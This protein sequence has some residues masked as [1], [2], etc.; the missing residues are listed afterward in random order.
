MALSRSLALLF[1]CAVSVSSARADDVYTFIIKKQEEKASTHWTLSEWLKTRDR[2]AL[3]DMWLALHSPSPYE[4]YLGGDLQAASRTIGSNY[5]AMRAQAGA[6]ASIFGLGIE[7]E[8]AP[9]NQSIGQ[10]NLRIFGYHDQ[11]TNITLHGGVRTRT[12]PSAF[13]SAIT[14]VS[15]TIYISRFFGVDGEWRH[16]F[17]A[18]PSESSTSFVGNRF[19]GGAFI[20]FKFLRLY[21][22]YFQE[23]DIE[24]SGVLGG[25][26]IYF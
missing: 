24:R 13:R 7:R 15:M 19:E 25:A 26:R 4:F 21:G 16:Y 23:T 20:D 1:L 11:S 10:F 12:S 14:G 5:T 17:A 6:Y 3:M 8:F 22:Q 2:M 18:A 9:I